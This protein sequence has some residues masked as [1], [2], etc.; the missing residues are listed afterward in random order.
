[1]QRLSLPCA[2]EAGGTPICSIIRSSCRTSAEGSMRAKQ[3]CWRMQNVTWWA[4]AHRHTPWAFIGRG[5]RFSR[6]NTT[7]STRQA[8]ECLLFYE[9]DD[10]D[11]D[12]DDR[13]HA[14]GDAYCL[15][16]LYGPISSNGQQVQTRL[17]CQ[18]RLG[19]SRQ[20]GSTGSYTVL[21]HRPKDSEGLRQPTHP[22]GLGHLQE[23]PR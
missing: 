4:A 16:L 19:Q 14:H 11:V 5:S 21:A 3:H 9:N 17:L 6:K 13:C 10:D 18:L 15:C 7:T 12:D 2:Q 1:M 22:V 20:R 23:C 8:H